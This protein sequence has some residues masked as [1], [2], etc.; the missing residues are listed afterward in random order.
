MFDWLI[1]GAGFAGCVLAERLAHGAGDRVLIIDRRLHI[2]GDAG[3]SLGEG[4][5]LPLGFHP[6]LDHASGNRVV[7]CLTRFTGGQHR[8]ERT[9]DGSTGTGRSGMA[10]P[11][12][13]ASRTDGESGG[14][15]TPLPCPDGPFTDG[16]LQMT[17]AQDYTRMFHAMLAYPNI[18][19]MLNTDFHE[20]EDI[21]RF[22]RLIYTDAIDRYFGYCYGRLPDRSI[23]PDAAALVDGHRHGVASPAT[24]DGMVGATPLF[25]GHRHGFA[26]PAAET[27]MIRGTAP[28]GQSEDLY[29]RYR[30]LADATPDVFFVGQ[31]PTGNHSCTPDEEVT[32]ALAA[33]GQI[34][35]ERIEGLRAQTAA[36][37]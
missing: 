33:Y 10:S 17:A 37:G 9:S 23:R 7:Q 22:R 14:E 31:P 29:R 16:Y 20:I 26:R 3:G 35:A 12:G 5:T 1:V 6:L 8:D 27:G 19:I 34:T 32:Q 15:A 24:E 2:G 30:E 13:A 28:G 11:T 18:K 21:V 25:N 4:N 36:S